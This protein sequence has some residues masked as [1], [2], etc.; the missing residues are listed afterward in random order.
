VRLFEI[1][2]STLGMPIQ[3]FKFGDGRPE[4][5]VVAGMHG[6]EIEAIHLAHSTMRELFGEASQPIL[7]KTGSVI[8]I[9]ILN[10]DGFSL[11]RRW[12]SNGVD[13]N[14]NFPSKDWTP[15]ASCERYPPGPHAGSEPETQS[16]VEFLR[17]TRPKIVLD[18]HSYRESVLMP[19]WSGDHSRVEKLASNFAAEVEIEIQRDSLG[20]PVQGGLHTW[21]QEHGIT[22]FTF[23]V[24]RDLSQGNI[25]SRYLK[26]TVKF[27]TESLT[28]SLGDP[29]A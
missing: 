9:P 11:A 27:I 4:I 24:L 23:E 26:P 29:D 10:P 20:Y 21:C 13:L 5:V 8:I 28:L 22:H 16:L 12:T 25:D 17:K 14:R 18:I 7:H 2:T 15:V 6:D 19:T 3:A 1:G